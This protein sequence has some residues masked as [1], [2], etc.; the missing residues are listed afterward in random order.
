MLNLLMTYFVA[1]LKAI[2]KNGL[3]KYILAMFQ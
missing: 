2:V 3:F 1:A